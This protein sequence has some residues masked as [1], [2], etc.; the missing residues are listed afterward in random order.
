MLERTGFSQFVGLDEKDEPSLVQRMSS[1]DLPVDG[2]R[3]GVFTRLIA[4]ESV[5]PADLASGPRTLP[6]ADAADPGLVRGRKHVPGD[7]GP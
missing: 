7:P 3:Y 2:E 4:K 5:T 6:P 1:A